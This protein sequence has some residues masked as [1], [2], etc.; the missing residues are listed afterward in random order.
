[1]IA[2]EIGLFTCEFDGKRYGLLDVFDSGVNGCAKCICVE[3]HV[4]CNAS[5]CHE[6]STE[7]PTTTTAD[8]NPINQDNGLYSEVE[9]LN[10][11]S[12][13]QQEIIDTDSS[14]ETLYNPYQRGIGAPYRNRARVYVHQ[15]QTAN[16]H[17]RYA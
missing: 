6:I 4:Y 16:R 5:R 7:T 2:I 15:I 8:P 3:T 14:E 12:L 11:N 10:G 17:N 1:M 9:D 13:I